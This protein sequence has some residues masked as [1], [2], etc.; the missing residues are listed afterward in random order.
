MLHT[1]LM[2]VLLICTT[3]RAGSMALPYDERLRQ[4]LALQQARQW[5]QALQVIGNL[6]MPDVPTPAL[7]RLY[8]LRATLALSLSTPETAI[9]DLQYVLQTYPPLADYA[10]WHLLQYFA[11]QDRLGQA[12]TVLATLTTHYPFSVLLPEAYLLLAQTQVR[13]AQPA[14][15]QATLEHLRNTYRLQPLL[16]EALFLLARLYEESNNLIAAAQMLQQLGETYPTHALATEALQRSTLLLAQ[17]PPEQRPVPAPEQLLAS[18]DGLIQARQWQEVEARLAVL[19]KLVQSPALVIRVWLK[20][21][22]VALRRQSFDQARATVYT[23]LQQYPEGDHVAEALYLLGRIEQQQNKPADSERQYRRVITE[24]TTTSWAAEALAALAQMLA[25]RQDL[26]GAGEL[27]Q[28]LKNSFG[29]LKPTSRA[30]TSCPRSSTG[31]HAQHRTAGSSRLPSVCIDGLST[32]I[33]CITTACM[34]HNTCS[35]LPYLPAS[36]CQSPCLLL[37]GRRRRPFSCRRFILSNPVRHNFISCARTSYSSYSCTRRPPGK[38]VTWRH[39]CLTLQQ[40]GTFLGRC[41][42]R[43]TAIWPRFA[44][45]IAC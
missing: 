15:A 1:L 8:F 3:L 21:A 29:T 31:T 34:Q 37:R 11:A 4:A 45:S 33:R 18:L 13:L 36:R 28:R 38:F 12:E 43:I 7:A 27:Y 2:A 9:P 26:A 41:V 30:P 20:R 10:G 17:L 19:E 40:P 24:Y 22:I 32:T 23:L 25:E 44:T 35:M 39:Y 16:P 6:D 5:Q 14:P 42:W